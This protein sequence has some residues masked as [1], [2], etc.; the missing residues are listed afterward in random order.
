MKQLKNVKKD[1]VEKNKSA[2]NAKY[3]EWVSTEH[4]CNH[5]KIC[6]SYQLVVSHLNS[7]DILIYKEE[8]GGI[9]KSMPL[10]L[11]RPNS[12]WCF[13]H[14]IFCGFII[15]QSFVAAN[16]QFVCIGPISKMEFCDNNRLYPDYIFG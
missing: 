5:R 4:Y 2:K 12:F 9:E 15:A 3:F 1:C 10:Y 8:L 13:F 11:M 16:T 7:I 6:A 14:H